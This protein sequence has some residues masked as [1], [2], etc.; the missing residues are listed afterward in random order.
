METFVFIDDTARERERVRQ[1]LPAITVLGEDLFALRR[2]LLTDPRLQP[3]RVTPE[4]ASRTNLVRAQLDRS[5][6]RMAMDDEAAFIASLNIASTVSRLAPGADGASLDR[7]RELFERTTQFNA[8]GRRFTR[9]ELERLIASPDGR[10]Y[11]LHMRDRFADHGLV[12]A[13]AVLDDSVLNMALSCRVI[14][15]GGDRALLDQVVAETSGPS[16]RGRIIPTE[17]NIPARNLYSECGFTAAGAGM[18][19][20]AA[21]GYQKPPATL[22]AISGYA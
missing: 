20:T 2:V 6:L 17:R 9:L 8:T 18:W 1:A 16:L 13:A 22:T 7:V 19:S 14:G 3:A 10:L 15:L 12:G 21:P 5:R 11:T 4:A